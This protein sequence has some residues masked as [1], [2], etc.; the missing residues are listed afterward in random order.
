MAKRNTKIYDVAIVGAGPAGITAAFKLREAGFSVTV[1][2]V[3]D[4][5]YM[6]VDSQTGEWAFLEPGS[7]N[8]QL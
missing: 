4:D 8:V 6:V 2:D 5:W 7:L 3:I 1:F